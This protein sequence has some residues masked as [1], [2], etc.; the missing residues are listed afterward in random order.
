MI[1]WNVLAGG[2]VL[3]ALHGRGRG[4]EHDERTLAA[5]AHDGDV[6]QYHRPKA[7]RKRKSSARHRC[8]A[9]IIELAEPWVKGK[10]IPGAR[11]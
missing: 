9:R 11:C 5:R 4:A 10:T 1:L 8:E 7:G 2:G 3:V 6:G